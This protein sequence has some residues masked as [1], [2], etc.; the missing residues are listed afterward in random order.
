MA[1]EELFALYEKTGNR[2]IYEEVYFTRRKMLAVFGCLSILEGKPEYLH[3]LEE[4]LDGICE[5]ECWRCPPMWR[6]TVIRTGV[7]AWICSPP[8]QLRLWLRSSA[9]WR[10]AAGK[11]AEKGTGQC[12]PPY[13]GAFYEFPA[14]L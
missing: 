13:P 12:F 2:L 4:V 1:G 11:P 3:K 9:W 10:P 5:E 7:S 14:A 8:K 6:G